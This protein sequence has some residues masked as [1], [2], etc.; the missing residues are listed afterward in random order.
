MARVYQPKKTSTKLIEGLSSGL[1]G[2]FVFIVV[3]F[4]VDAVTRAGDLLYSVSRI[5][6][7]FTGGSGTAQTAPT[8]LGMPFVVGALL[9]LA[10]FALA[11]IGFI[12]YLP[13]VYRLGISKGLFGAIYGIFVWLA[14]FLVLLRFVNSDVVNSLNIWL[15]LISC[16]L[17]G[18]ADGWSLGYVMS[19]K[20]G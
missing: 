2:G 19:R 14:A 13:I 12:S 5:G 1:I 20:G 15:L 10:I 7:I 6:S 8:T 11:G 17:A 4:L 9:M 3:T 18:A 16:V